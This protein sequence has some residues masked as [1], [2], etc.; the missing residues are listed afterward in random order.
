V[1]TTGSDGLT[2]RYLSEDGDVKTVPVEDF[3]AGR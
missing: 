3:P 1:S 2:V